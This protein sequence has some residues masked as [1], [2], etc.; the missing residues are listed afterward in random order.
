LATL[1]VMIQVTAAERTARLLY[2]QLLYEQL[3]Y[4]HW[5]ASTSVTLVVAGRRLKLTGI[6]FISNNV[7]SSGEGVET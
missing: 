7:K 1:A 6:R 3:L 4:E 5:G 2:E